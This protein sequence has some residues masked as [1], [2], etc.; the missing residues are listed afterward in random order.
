MIDISADGDSGSPVFRR[1]GTDGANLY[2]ILW[3]GG[4]DNDEGRLF[5]FSSMMFVHLDL[6]PL[7]VVEEPSPAVCPSNQT[8]CEKGP[9]GECL[10]CIPH[11][12]A[13]P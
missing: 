7:I 6:F 13:C 11:G 1:V 3:G 8:C 9:T 10:L 12:A 2:G 4:V 5:W